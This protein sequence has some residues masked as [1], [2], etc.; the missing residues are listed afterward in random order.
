MRQFLA[1]MN[2]DLS[3]GERL[4]MKRNLNELNCSKRIQW[5]HAY[6]L[7]DVMTIWC[8]KSILCNNYIGRATRHFM[9]SLDRHM[10]GFDDKS[11]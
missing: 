2:N 4:N 7:F 1:L 3:M 10:R 5:I 11:E 6:N 9:Y 8:I